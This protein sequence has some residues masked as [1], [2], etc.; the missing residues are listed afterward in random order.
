[1]RAGGRDPWVRGEG[2]VECG[3]HCEESGYTGRRNKGQSVG[4]FAPGV[5]RVG[6]NGYG[7]NAKGY[8]DSR[9]VPHTVFVDGLPEGISKRALYVKFGKC[10]YILDVF[11]SRK[12][13]VR[14]EGPFPFIRYKSVRGAVEAIWA[15]NN[16]IWGNNKLLVTISKYER[17]GGAEN[18]GNFAENIQKAKRSNTGR[19]L[20]N[21]EEEENKGE[22]ATTSKQNTRKEV[23]GVWAEDQKERLQRSLMGVCSKP[24]EFRK[25]MEFLL[26][27]WKGPG[28][29]ELRDIGPYRCLI[30]FSSREIRD[31]A[32]ENQLLLSIFDELRHHWDFFWC[33]SRRVSVKV[34]GGAFEVFVKEVGAEAYSVQSH[35]ERSEEYSELG[36][37]TDVGGMARCSPAESGESLIAKNETTSKLGNGYNPVIDTIINYTIN[38]NHDIV[39]AELMPS[40]KNEALEMNARVSAKD[41]EFVCQGVGYDPMLL[42]AQISIKRMVGP[43]DC[44]VAFPSPSSIGDSGSDSS[45]TCPYP[46]GFGPCT[47]ECHVHHNEIRVAVSSDCVKETPLKLQLREGDKMI[48]SPNESASSSGESLFC[49]NKDLTA[50]AAR[51]AEER[52]TQ[53]R[54]TEEEASDET[55]YKINP[56][57]AGADLD[58]V[59]VDLENVDVGIM[60]DVNNEG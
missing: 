36:Y 9:D 17:K 45:D 37:E 6:F 50:G 52:H 5:R 1:M 47:E 7:S 10:G 19:K 26:D 23:E 46:P 20:A 34:E 48:T 32:I 18:G 21:G 3:K 39:H 51:N 14:T 58:V 53:E 25:I 2:C 38:D 28:N 22:L 12:Q 11:I 42:E 41:N 4:G 16:T 49:I 15:L 60:F 31:A 56:Q 33:Q 29:I 40:R 54:S 30:T 57:A 13:R 24:I 8:S 27:E 59:G 44:G 55:L 35:P 43:N